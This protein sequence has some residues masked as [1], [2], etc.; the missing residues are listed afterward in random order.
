M[1]L[2]VLVAL[3]AAQTPRETAAAA[4]PAPGFHLLKSIPVAGQGGWDYL[5]LDADGRRLFVTH[6][7]HVDVLDLASEQVVGEIKDTAGVH[8][9]ALAPALKRGFVSDGRSNT[10][11]IFDLETLAKLGEVKT[12]TKP[13]AI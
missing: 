4:L 7:Y 13:D 11:T 6:G 10:V 1:L 9:V 5:T 8:G 12:G 2:S 3:L